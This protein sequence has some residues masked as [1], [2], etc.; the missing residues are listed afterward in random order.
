MSLFS[1]AVTLSREIC[2]LDDLKKRA[3]HAGVFEKRANELAT[4]TEAINRLDDA[5]DVIARQGISVTSLDRVLVASL[6]SKLTDLKNRYAV[7]K[8]IMLEPFP[9]KDVRYF[10]MAPLEKLPVA[11]KL[12]LET[13]WE[14]WSK[15]QL[16]L[17][18]INNDVLDTLGRITA[19]RES[20]EKVR[21]LI[22]EAEKII[23]NLP[24][25]NKDVSCLAKLSADIGRAWQN[26]AGD[27]IP[28]DVLVFLS[29]AGGPVGAQY[30]ALTSEVLV[31]LSLHGLID[32]FRIRMG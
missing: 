26:L 29:A 23:K 1:R 6:R 5:I 25:S 12:A 19:L 28:R 10:L 2:A 18:E 32:S 7:D 17:P 21:S 11:A 4:P 31:W 22:R 16:K 20:V 15:L 27:G 3:D 8:S 14:T 24:D 9:T 13:A 30:S